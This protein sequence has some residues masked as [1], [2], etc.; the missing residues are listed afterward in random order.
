M[1]PHGGGGK[2]PGGKPPGDYSS[3]GPGYSSKGPGNGHSSE[4]SYTSKDASATKSYSSAAPSSTGNGTS[5]DCVLVDPTKIPETGKTRKYE[6]TI[7]YRDIKPDGVLKPGIVINGGF[8][9]PTI[10]AN[11]GDMI[12]VTVHNALNNEGAT[13]HWHGLLQ[14]GTQ[15]MDGVP[16]V[17]QCPITPGSTF[18]YTFKADSYG[19]TWYHSHYSA[20]YSGGAYGAI[21]IHGPNDSPKCADYDK[22]LGPVLV[23]DWYHDSYYSLVNQTMNTVDGRPPASNNNLVNGKNNYP[24]QNTTLECTPNAGLAKFK[25][26]S[27]K[28]YRLRLINPS[29]ES[30]Q[31]IS[32]DGHKFTVIAQ[33]FVPIVPYETDLITLAIG[34]RTDVI[35]EATGTSKD[36]FWF[37]STLGVGPQACSLP[38][39]ISPNAMAV[40]YYEDADP[41]TIPTTTSTI[42]EDRI[43]TCSNDPLTQTVP[44]FPI[45]ADV[46]GDLHTETLNI[47][48]GNN[49]TN[50]IWTV[51]A[52]STRVDYGLSLLNEVQKGTLNPKPE[53]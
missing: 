8:P 27:G 23:G 10:E 6:F 38:D 32:I 17:G 21:I 53:W 36:S 20:Q 12:E 52:I 44:L 45:S 25:F 28:K 49:G 3:S 16:S 43:F 11:W 29:S 41:D 37:R 39:G 40:I 2:P 46:V 48:F 35:V 14:Q 34:Q 26:E 22:D 33:D 7:S 18:V 30:T 47:D 50:F 51:N 24:C 31:K 5:G 13:L 19:T 1:P 15:F 42:T 4:A 9:G